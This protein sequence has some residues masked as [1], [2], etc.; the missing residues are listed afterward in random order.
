LKVSE[1]LRLLELEGDS[2]DDEQEVEADMGK[3][4]VGESSKAGAA[5]G[6]GI[7]PAP[8]AQLP[9]P[10]LQF[11]ILLSML[12]ILHPRLQRSIQVGFCRRHCRLCLR[13]MR[14]LPLIRTN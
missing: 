1:A 10:V 6:L 13:L 7:S 2:D 5:K 9:T 14:R 3:L 8:E 12:S 4:E 11:R